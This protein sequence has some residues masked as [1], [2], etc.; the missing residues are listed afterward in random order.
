MEKFKLHTPDVISANIE[1][2]AAL[3]PG[4]IIEALD[5]RTGLLR[6]SN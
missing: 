6:R 5:E 1:K 2:L 4:C 3:F